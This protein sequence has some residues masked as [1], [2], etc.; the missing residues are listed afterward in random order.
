VGSRNRPIMATLARAGML[1]QLISAL[2]V[3]LERLERLAPQPA[4]SPMAERQLA[5][6]LYSQTA[7]LAAIAGEL[8][9]RAHEQLGRF[10]AEMVELACHAA[11]P[12][13]AASEVA[14]A[15]L[16]L[17]RLSP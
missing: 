13:T 4:A 12:E 7:I 2:R 14:D 8:D 3:S 17:G 6:L 10:G 16:G 9:A 15:F 1:D 11:D 5:I